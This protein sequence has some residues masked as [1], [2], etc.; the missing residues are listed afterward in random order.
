MKRSAGKGVN[1]LLKTVSLQLVKKHRWDDPKTFIPF[2]ETIKNAQEAGL[3]VGDY[4]DLTHNYPG[5]TQETIDQMELLG[6]FAGKIDR[7]CEI[8]PGSG[9][10]L[11]KTLQHCKPSYYEIYE[12]AQEWAEWLKKRYNVILQPS[13]AISLASTPSN[14]ID[15]AHAHKTLPTLNFITTINYFFELSRVVREGGFIVFDLMTDACLDVEIM[16]KWAAAGIPGGSSYPNFMSKHCTIDFFCSRGFELVGNF[17][18]R[19]R[20]GNTEYFVFKRLAVRQ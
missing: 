14:S 20:P 19:M 11:E 13:D 15:L 10:Y 9:R 4:I 7:I 5:V 8:G 2:T 17:I 6:V 1:S 18:V 3:S 12:T 16:S